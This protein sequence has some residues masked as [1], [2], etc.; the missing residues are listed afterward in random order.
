MATDARPP[1]RSATKSDATDRNYTTTSSNALPP[2]SNTAYSIHHESRIIPP[3]IP[4]LSLRIML[5][6]LGYVCK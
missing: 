3:T 6:G 2:L 1:V 5:H 4:G